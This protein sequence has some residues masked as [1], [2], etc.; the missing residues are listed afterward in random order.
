MFL[1]RFVSIKSKDSMKKSHFHS[2]MDEVTLPFSNKQIFLDVY[3]IIGNDY[4]TVCYFN[5]ISK[6]ITYMCVKV[7][8]GVLYKKFVTFEHFLKWIQYKMSA[9]R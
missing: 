4:N 6:L 7:K 8:Y 2:E 3:I 5:H 1:I 9:K